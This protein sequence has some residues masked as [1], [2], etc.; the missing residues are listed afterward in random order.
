MG[1]SGFCKEPYL[2]STGSTGF[3]VW[4]RSCLLGFT[5]FS[6]VF[7]GF[8]SVLAG[9]TELEWVSL[10]LAVSLIGFHWLFFIPGLVRSFILFFFWWVWNGSQWVEAYEV[11]RSGEWRR[12]VLIN[13]C[14]DVGATNPR[15]GR[16]RPFSFSCEGCVA[17]ERNSQKREKRT[18]PI[19]FRWKSKKKRTRK[20]TLTRS[21]NAAHRLPKKNQ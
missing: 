14:R 16:E 9:R 19:R 8:N 12:C 13:R 10:A 6:W 21:G 20:K 18:E 7:L 1:G 15:D 3:L 2:L 11:G 4:T 5:G 17:L